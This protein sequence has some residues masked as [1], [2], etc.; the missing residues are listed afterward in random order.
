MLK[1]EVSDANIR[2]VF[3]GKLDKI[4]KN[5]NSI[6]LGRYQNAAS[7][8]EDLLNS[9][10][11]AD[12]TGAEAKSDAKLCI[13]QVLPTLKRKIYFFTVDPN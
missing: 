1:S 13:L 9:Y 8:M 4:L 3:T 6:R 5:F 11:D 7:A 2:L 10:S 12:I